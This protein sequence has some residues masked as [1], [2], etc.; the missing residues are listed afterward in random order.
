MARPG[1]RVQNLTRIPSSINICRHYGEYI[2]RSAAC[3][4]PGFPRLYLTAVFGSGKSLA[5]DA[6]LTDCGRVCFNPGNYMGG[7][8]VPHS[9]WKQSLRSQSH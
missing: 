1:P 9:F 3:H 6:D 7:C 4:P 5:S 2:V 8:V